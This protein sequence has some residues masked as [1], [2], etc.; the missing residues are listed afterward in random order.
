MTQRNGMI[1]LVGNV[2]TAPEMKELPARTV[3][4]EVYDPVTDGV[5]EQPVTLD[6]REVW[7]FS[8][9]I[10]GQD[11][12][13]NDLETR[14]VRCSDWNGYCQDLGQGDFVKLTGYLHIEDKEYEGE[15]RTFRDFVVKRPPLILR[16]RA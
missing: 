8:L 4:R 3:T 14:W 7:N 2:G 10:N 13:G 11:E 6:A 9:A 12:D 1:E 5:V 15:A 16:K